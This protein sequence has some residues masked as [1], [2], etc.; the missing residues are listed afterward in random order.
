MAQS[1]V[2]FPVW[3]P[4]GAPLIHRPDPVS[5]AGTPQAC[6]VSPAPGALG[7]HKASPAHSGLGATPES[8]PRPRQRRERRGRC[9]CSPPSAPPGQS[10]LRRA[11]SPSPLSGAAR[12]VGSGRALTTRCSIPFFFPLELHAT[13]GCPGCHDRP[14]RY[15]GPPLRHGAGDRRVSSPAGRHVGCGLR[16][17]A[18][19]GVYS[20]RQVRDDVWLSYLI[21][22]G[23]GLFRVTSN[24]VLGSD[25]VFVGGG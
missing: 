12:R 19:R 5:S 3:L 14:V 4:S 2:P 23:R 25:E 17:S 15:R 22:G 13:P 16:V 7:L 8:P 20:Y 11:M 6:V 24:A 10:A 9:G 18:S 1:F 21:L